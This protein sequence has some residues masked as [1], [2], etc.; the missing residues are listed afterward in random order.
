MEIGHSR[1]TDTVLRYINSDNKYEMEQFITEAKKQKFMEIDSQE[2]L[3]NIFKD[4]INEF[5]NNVTQ[6]ELLDLRSYTGYNFK[7]INA[8]LRNNW[9]YEE[10]G[11]LDMETKKRF[12]DISNKISSI[13]NKFPSL[14]YNFTTYRGTTIDSFSKYGIK[15]INDL[16]FMQNKY[17]FEEGFTSTSVVEDTCY[18]NKDLDTG[19]NYNVEIK[20]LITPEYEDGALLLNNDMSYSINQ[21]EYLINKGSLS[22]VVGVEINEQQNQAV[23]TVVLIPRKKW[24]LVKTNEMKNMK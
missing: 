21:N 2:A 11:L 10:N 20:Y 23:L 15:S 5:L 22:K 9:T 14:P 19:K 8:I 6:D 13:L 1:T 18:F 16:K 17:M 7:N 12:F 3:K 24:D 4:N